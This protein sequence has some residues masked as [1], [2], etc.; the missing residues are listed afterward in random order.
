MT[1][2]PFSI[3][4]RVFLFAGKWRLPVPKESTE[5]TFFQNIIDSAIISL[6][7]VVLTFG[8]GHPFELLKTRMQANPYIHSGLLLSREIYL[9]TGIRG[10]YIGGLPNFTR[11]FFKGAY[12]TP[13][14]GGLAHFYNQQ[15]PKLGETPKA[16]LTGGTMAIA[17]TLFIPLERIQVWLMTNDKNNASCLSF[18]TQRSK[19]SLSLSQDLFK[20]TTISLTRSTVAWVS[21]LVPE[22][23]IRRIVLN[24]SPRVDN[25]SSVL[26]FPEQ[27]FIGG[28]SGIINAVCTLPLDTIKTNV[29]KEGFVEKATVKKMW[30]IGKDLITTHGF[31]KGLYPSFLVRLFHYCIVGIITADLIQKVDA[32]WQAD[33]MPTMR[34]NR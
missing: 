6:P 33:N 9:Q 22:R 8:A 3:I 28:L 12:Q 5:N 31:I 18:F 26:P 15:F 2:L 10:F 32:V 14:R 4:L 23:E 29:Q 34:N 20:G 19:Q 16:A 1:S 25:T 30:G 13:L 27:A 17:D 7:R 11:H 24:I 21:Y